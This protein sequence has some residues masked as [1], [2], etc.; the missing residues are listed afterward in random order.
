MKKKK[1]NKNSK[2][3]WEIKLETQIRNLRQLEK[4]LRQKKNARIGCDEKIKAT[5]LEHTIK[6]EEINRKILAKKGSQKKLGTIKQFKQ[7]RTSRKQRKKILSDGRGKRCKDI[8]TT[9]DDGG[10][11]ILEPNLGTYRS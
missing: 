6:Q 9:E 3:G 5:R 1:T 7:N 11:T 4:M 10:K 2:P 8:P